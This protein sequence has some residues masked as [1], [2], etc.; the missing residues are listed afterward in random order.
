M[1]LGDLIAN[2]ITGTVDLAKKA[3]PYAA[4]AGVSYYAYKKLMERFWFLDN[5]EQLVMVNL[6]QTVVKNGPGMQL[7]SPFVKSVELKK[8][9]LLEP[10]DYVKVKDRLSGE[11][12]VE[13]GPK[14]LFMGPYDEIMENVA[15]I[16]LTPIMYCV[17]TDKKA[18]TRRIEKGPKVLFPG[19]YEDIAKPKQAIS[20]GA[21]QYCHILDTATGSLQLVKGECLLFLEPTWEVQNGIQNA[22]SLKNIEYCRLIDSK[23]GKIRLEKGEQM[24][25]PTPTEKPLDRETVLKATNLKSFE[26][27]KILDTS[28]GVLR[29]E[30]GEQLIY[31]KPTEQLQGGVQQAISLKKVEYVRLIDAKSGKIRVEKGEQLVFPEATEEPLD[32]DGKLTALNLKASEYVR[33]L[34]NSTGVLRVEKG[35]QLLYLEPTEEFVEG[36]QQAISLKKVEY[37]RLIDK[38]NGKIRVEKGE[39]MVFPGPY[40]YPMDPEGKLTAINLKV[41]EYIKILD[42]ATGTVR[43]EQGEQVIFLGPTE[44]LLLNKGKQPAN[45]IDEETAV[46]IRNKKTGAQELIQKKGLFIPKAEEEILEV[47]KLIKLADY[48]CLILKNK[49]GELEFYYGSEE[50]RGDK[51]R[52]FFIPPHYEPNNLLWSKGRRRETRNLTISRIDCRAQ[53]MNFEFNCRTSDNVEL[54]LEG[55]FFWQVKDVETMVRMTGDTTGDICNHARSRFISLVSKVTLKVFMESFNQ[56]AAQ[57]QAKDDEFYTKRGIE[58]HTLEV[59]RYQCADAST[60]A[61]LEQIIQETTNRMNRLSQQESANEIN[62]AE[63]EGEIAQENHRSNLIKVK[64]THDIMLASNAGLAEAEKVKTFLETTAGTVKDLNQ[65]IGI[66]NVLRKGETVSSVAAGNSRLYFTPNDVNLSIETKETRAM[67]EY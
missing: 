1:G 37:V 41:F 52:S 53:F 42:T 17:V 39:Q 55:T 66:W 23:T 20:L 60:A 58:I 47:Q 29:I 57:A 6:T 2:S 46:K 18:G 31:L 16:S 32:Y 30:R 4:A 28:T 36:V 40:E 62:M 12:R 56:I 7:V 9:A 43:V 19:P 44:G 34:D 59:T 54:I 48:E 38:N 35:E 45:E 63:L 10:T 33:I 27:V 14:L 5:D 50:K 61:I 67:D 8:G 65:R 22:I 3:A 64:N 51:P 24:V 11:V 15:G 26:Y 49:S 13:V 21:T 25:F